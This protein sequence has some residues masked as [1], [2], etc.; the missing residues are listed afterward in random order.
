MRRSSAVMRLAFETFLLIRQAEGSPTH[1]GRVLGIRTT[2]SD[3]YLFANASEEVGDILETELFGVPT[4]ANLRAPFVVA[5]T[6]GDVSLAGFDTGNRLQLAR[7]A[8]DT[9]KAELRFS[10]VATIGFNEQ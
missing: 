2:L 6:D 7:L 8:V 1:S 5:R 9:N 3:A 10:L 4:N